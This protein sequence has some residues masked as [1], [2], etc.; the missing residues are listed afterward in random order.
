MKADKVIKN[1]GLDGHFKVNIVG[2]SGG[3]WVLWRSSAC[4]ISIVNH[5]NQVI[6]VEVSDNKGF[7]PFLPIWQSQ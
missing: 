4:M 1:S 6:H 5:S 7:L 2:F 3:I